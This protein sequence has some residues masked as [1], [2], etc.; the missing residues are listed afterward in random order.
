M[1]F[2]CISIGYCLHWLGFSNYV[3]RK[4][5]STYSYISTESARSLRSN[6]CHPLAIKIHKRWTIFYDRNKSSCCHFTCSVFVCVC[7]WGHDLFT[8]TS[9]YLVW[10]HEY[11]YVFVCVCV[12][13]RACLRCTK[14]YCL[15]PFVERQQKISTCFFP[16]VCDSTDGY[17]FGVGFLLGRE[18]SVISATRSQARMCQIHFKHIRNTTANSATWHTHIHTKLCIYAMCMIYIRIRFTIRVGA[19][20]ANSLPVSRSLQQNCQLGEPNEMAI[21]TLTFILLK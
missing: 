14:M 6:I 11:V 5:S 4:L 15:I 10:E 16:L 17:F 2:V 9:T 19:G 8:F 13:L 7:V 12:C 20:Q 3:L 21:K 18:G 1:Y